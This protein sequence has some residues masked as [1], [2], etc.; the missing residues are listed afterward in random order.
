MPQPNPRPISLVN[1]IVLIM[2]ATMLIVIGSLLYL[3]FNPPEIKSTAHW[4]DPPPN[5]CISENQCV[6]LSSDP[7]FNRIT[8]QAIETNNIDL[9]NDATSYYLQDYSGF[10][11]QQSIQVCEKVYSQ[12]KAYSEQ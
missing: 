7:E 2:A 10:D 3:Y 8:I 4:P 11:E 1:L 5:Y 9:C 12:A 6:Q